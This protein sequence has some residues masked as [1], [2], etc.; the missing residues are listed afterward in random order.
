MELIYLYIENYRDILKEV[1]F[2][3]SSNYLGSY[4]NSNLKIEF[5]QI[6]NDNFFGTKISNLSVI[7]GENGS[8]KTTLMRFFL[9]ELTKGGNANTLN[10][11]FVAVYANKGNDGFSYFAKKLKPT[12]TG[13]NLIELHEPS[14]DKIIYY[15]PIDSIQ[16][17]NGVFDEEIGNLNNLTNRVLINKYIENNKFPNQ[18]INDVIGY[19]NILNIEVYEEYR[20]W[21]DFFAN[22]EIIDSIGVKIA[23]NLLISLENV[24]NLK[25]LH[26]EEIEF[27][28]GIR[29]A[30]EF[31]E[32]FFQPNDQNEITIET[33][34]SFFYLSFV[35]GF[36]KE[37]PYK[38]TEIEVFEYLINNVMN[39][40]NFAKENKSYSGLRKFFENISILSLPPSL[41]ENNQN[42]I[43]GFWNEKSVFIIDFIESHLRPIVINDFQNLKRKYNQRLTNTWHLVPPE[44]YLNTKKEIS[45]IRSFLK[46]YQKCFSIYEPLR[47]D[48]ADN[49]RNSYFYSSGE[50][51]FVKLFARLDYSIKFLDPNSGKNSILFLLDEAELTLHPSWQRKCVKVILDYLNTRLPDNYNCQLI[52]TTHS[53]ILLSD[54]PVG[55]II[56]IDKNDLNLVGTNKSSELTFGANIHR[57]YKRSFLQKGGLIGE[58]AKEKIEDLISYL[59]DEKT[60][61]FEWNQT[62]S[63]LLIDLVGE[64]LIRERLL[65][66]YRNKFKSIEDLIRERDL[67]TRQIENRIK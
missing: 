32:T 15:S 30:I 64:D 56:Q 29:W 43:I 50:S 59:K 51:N 9:E 44:L 13:E 16:I 23:D 36:I 8:G 28:E 31:Y 57:L 12:N 5:K 62:N 21:A 22:S 35:V 18:N 14:F 25:F 6:V 65:D 26:R 54:I 48:W 63:K 55:N 60:S 53:P 11:S 7:V 41:L 2:Q 33:I 1:E 49:N 27:F 67:L 47:F 37:L 10:T 34:L 17:H 58:F 20:R 46:A 42:E 4:K 66:L 38:N 40:F 39:E 19:R 24:S 3:F 61:K 45:Q 52:L